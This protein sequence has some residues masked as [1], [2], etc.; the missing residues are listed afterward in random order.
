MAV[1]FQPAPPIPAWLAEEYPF[2]R[3]CAVVD[4]LRINFVD[5]GEGPAVVLLHGNPTWSFLWRKVIARLLPEGI[6]VIAP[7]LFG[8]GLSD[9]PA[10][11]KAHTLERHVDTMLRLFKALAMK[12]VT[13]AGQDWGG[14]IIAG[15]AARAQSS[16]RGAVFANTVL[17][18]P[19]KRRKATWFHRFAN[20]PVVSDI[21]FRGLNFPVPMLGRVQGDPASIG[22]L[23]KRAYRYPLN[24][25]RNR[26]APLALARM[27]PAH[28]DHPSV[29][30]LRE[31]AQWA[32][33]FEG[34]TELVWGMRDPILGPSLKRMR[35]TF[36]DAE[37]TET[38]AGHFL[39][40][41]V[42]D[43]LAQAIL[44]VVRA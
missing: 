38:Q 44:R 39:Q 15:V 3:R 36:P 41:E 1:I 37:V 25:W 11:L 6:R 43:A 42:P 12:D 26:A 10:D 13:I 32:K 33:H 20:V 5:D 2:A 34:P 29:P 7:D 22:K 18:P 23:A 8:L 40:E 9:K 21:A 27:V 28:D 16:V 24:S 30:V 19:S 14:P 31:T 4:D 35:A 17:S